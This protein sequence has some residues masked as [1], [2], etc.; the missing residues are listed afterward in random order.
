MTARLYGSNLM[1]HTEVRNEHLGAMSFDLC[2][3]SFENFIF[4]LAYVLLF[5]L[6]ILTVLVIGQVKEF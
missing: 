2:F 5:C 3:C 6:K 4:L 1:E